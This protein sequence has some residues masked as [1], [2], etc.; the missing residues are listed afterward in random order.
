MHVAGLA[1]CGGYGVQRKVAGAAQGLEGLAET[2]GMALMGAGGL[3]SVAGGVMFLL[4][5][6]TALVAGSTWF[7]GSF[8]VG[9]LSRARMPAAPVRALESAPTTTGIRCPPCSNQPA[10]PLT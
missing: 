3:I 6:T 1:W 9:A 2:A 4:V 5:A 8:S 7:A 10:R